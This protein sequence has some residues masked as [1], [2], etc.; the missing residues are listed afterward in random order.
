MEGV[1][2][3]LLLLLGLCALFLIRLWRFMARHPLIKL[4]DDA[5]WRVDVITE[6]EQGEPAHLQTIHLRLTRTR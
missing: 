3:F 1:F 4:L 6:N 2:L 5:A